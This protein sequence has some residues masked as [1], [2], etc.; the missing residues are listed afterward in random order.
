MGILGMLFRR[1][2]RW[3][4]NDAVWDESANYSSRSEFCRGCNGAYMAAKRRGLLDE[5]FPIA[6]R[7][8]WSNDLMV[9]F[10]ASKYPSR[11]SFSMAAPGAYRAA[12]KRG[13]LQMIDFPDKTKRERK[14]WSKS[15]PF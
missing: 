5:M 7:N 4:S 6:P 12:T 8:D 10:E 14:A 3:E 15:H 2:G 1:G 9:L 11:R 13:L